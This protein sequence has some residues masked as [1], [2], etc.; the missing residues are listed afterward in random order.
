M[1]KL[2]MLTGLGGPNISLTRGDEYECGEVEASRL[3]RAGFAVATDGFEP[4]ALEDDAEEQDEAAKA[5]AEAEAAEA[6]AKAKADAEAAAV[7]AEA[8]AKAKAE[9]A[10]AAAKPAA[11]KAKG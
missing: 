11:G 8:E 6:E 4:I 9:A 5:A 2:K 7:A 1:P 3:I 10:A